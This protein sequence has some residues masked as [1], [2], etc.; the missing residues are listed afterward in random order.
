MEE[1]ARIGWSTCY[2]ARS[3]CCL[4]KF[5]SKTENLQLQRLPGRIVAS[6]VRYM[7]ILAAPIRA[8]YARPVQWLFKKCTSAPLGLSMKTPFIS[9]FREEDTKMGKASY[10]GEFL[11]IDTSSSQPYTP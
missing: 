4:N 3:S 9:S 6:Y 1:P 2:R 11:C 5:E 10:P 8:W 7:Q